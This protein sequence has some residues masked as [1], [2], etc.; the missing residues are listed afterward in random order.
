MALT[1]AGKSS[2]ERRRG[3]VCTPSWTEMTRRQEDRRLATC[4]LNTFS[5]RS[6][7]VEIR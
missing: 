2:P 1:S 3:R 5:T 4:R 6:D 7:E